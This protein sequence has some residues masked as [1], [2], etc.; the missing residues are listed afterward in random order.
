MRRVILIPLLAFICS[1][2]TAQRGFSGPRGGAHFSGHFAPYRAGRYRRS[3]GYP[4]Y[5]FFGDSLYPD[6]FLDYGYPAA[7]QPPIIVMQ[8]AP[9]DR[10]QQF[11]KPEPPLVIEL[12]AG[13]Y[14]RVDA[15]DTSA[16]T[17]IEP[18]AAVDPSSGASEAAPVPLAS[19]TPSTILVFRDGRQEEIS[20]Y[21]ITGGVLYAQANYYTQGAWNRGI[22]LSSLNLSAT[23]NENRARGVRFQLPSAPNEVI[24][25]P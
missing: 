5:P 23:L 18:H 13:H 2:A 8:Q 3:G 4:L 17:A 15:G 25:G 10:T 11:A 22:E 9:G 21:T 19:P 12:R 14:V 16:S 1:S 6:D 7:S 20:D 24:V